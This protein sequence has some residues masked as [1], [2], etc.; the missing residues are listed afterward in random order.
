LAA[1]TGSL[2][3]GISVVKEVWGSYF[4][5]APDQR[6]HAEE[7]LIG[8]IALSM[9]HSQIED[10]FKEKPY[11][12]KIS[13]SGN[14]IYQF[15]RDWEF[16]QVLAN[17]DE[18]TISLGIHLKDPDFRPAKFSGWGTP[19]GESIDSFV[20]REGE[21]S[22]VDADC[23]MSGAT[24]YLA[25]YDIEDRP[26]DYQHVAIGAVDE[27][28]DT[29]SK[30]AFSGPCEMEKYSPNCNPP[31]VVNPEEPGLPTCIDE[32]TMRKQAK[33]STVIVTRGNQSITSEMLCRPGVVLVK[34]C[35][36]T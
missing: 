36:E 2:N 25:I 24:Y 30:V 3:D 17:R 34:T 21:P 23:G 14:H 5:S 13:A 12:Q 9:S 32:A 10:I 7:E 20:K 6:R 31:N 1:V 16:V 15:D 35:G 33:I 27:G 11:E 22:R 29:D 26:H 8:T 18:T 19:F 4:N 28:Q